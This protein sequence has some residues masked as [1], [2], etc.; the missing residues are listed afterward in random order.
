MRNLL[1]LI[2]AALVGVAAMLVWLMVERDR[3]NGATTEPP[4]ETAEVV[5]EAAPKPVPAPATATKPTPVLSEDEAKARRICMAGAAD[6]SLPD[7]G[8]LF[9]HY[10]YGDADTA[11]TSPPAGIKGGNCGLVTAG[12]AAALSAMLDAAKAENPDVAAAMRG[13]SCHRSVA[14]QAGLYCASGRIASRGYAGQARWVA[15]PGFSEHSTGYAID[16]GDRNHPECDVS[17]CFKST[18]VG[19]WLA[20]NAG[21]FGFVLSFPAGNAQG[22]SYEPWHYR[23]QGDG[24]AQSKFAH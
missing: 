2:L 4:I 24:V 11:L 8:T 20:A 5:E 18:P 9:G 1:I 23:W 16:F 21:R 3:G 13:I 6:G 17:T 15:P 19:E 10:R 22:V 7:A 12:T 14:R